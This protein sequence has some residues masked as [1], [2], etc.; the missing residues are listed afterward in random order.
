MVVPAY[1]EEKFIASVIDNVPE[2]VDKVFVINDASLDNT[3]RIAMDIAQTNAR[4]KVISHHLNCG[5]GRAIITGYKGCL[6]ENIDIVAVMAGDDQM[7]PE[8][9]PNLLDPIIEDKADYCVGDRLSNLKNMEGMSYWRCFG[10]LQLRWLTRIAAL[11]F[12]I[13]DPQNGYTAIKCETLSAID[14]DK[15]YPRYGYCN[16]LLV[17][18]SATRARI[19]NIAIPAVYGKEKSKIKYWKFIPILSWLLLKDFLWRISR[20]NRGV[21]KSCWR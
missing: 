5:V 21:R 2:Y 6:T 16:D 10:N 18:L 14:L 20:I 11:N 3:E 1:N 15:I 8:Q 7:K 19:V 12:N 13:R 4:T 9:L 17:K